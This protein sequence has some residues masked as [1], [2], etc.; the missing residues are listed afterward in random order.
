MKNS[1]SLEKLKSN[2]VNIMKRKLSI[3]IVVLLFV[4]MTDA[5][6]YA[7]GPRSS[8][9]QSGQFSVPT[10]TTVQ[11]PPPKQT[12]ILWSTYD[13][14]THFQ[15]NKLQVSL[16]KNKPRLEN[17]L[18]MK[19]HGHSFKIITFATK[20]KCE[21]EHNQILLENESGKKNTWSFSKDNTLIVID[22]RMDE[23]FARELESALYK[24]KK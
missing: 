17:K 4:A 16:E 24:L 10:P 15:K 3:L 9:S 2:E 19:Y 11:V 22:H 12:K 7:H 5:G 21:K 13:V 6:I 1:P 20:E 8:G 23:K 18:F 14:L